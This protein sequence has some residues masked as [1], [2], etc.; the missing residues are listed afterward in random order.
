MRPLWTACGLSCRSCGGT[1]PNAGCSPISTGGP[2]GGG[3][4]LA[5]PTVDAP[6]SHQEGLRVA[7]PTLVDIPDTGLF[8]VEWESAAVSK[9]LADQWL[10]PNGVPSRPTLREYIKRSVSNRT[11]FEALVPIGEKLHD[12][13]ESIPRPL[14]RWREEVAGGR[15]RRPAMNPASPIAPP[16]TASSCATCRSSSAIEVLGR[17][18]VRPNGSDVSGCRIVSDAPRV[19]EDTVRRTWKACM[20]RKSIMP[21]VQKYSKAI[22][23]RNGPFIP[24]ED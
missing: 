17:V 11:Y 13:G 9:L 2:P 14:A 16:I 20:W 1:I 15:L 24:P 10:P 12:R 6:P 5:L 21:A 19:P 22:A 3:M 8:D 18:G 7:R 23:E 4:G